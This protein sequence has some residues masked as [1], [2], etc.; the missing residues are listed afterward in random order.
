MNGVVSLAAITGIM[1][2]VILLANQ[3]YGKGKP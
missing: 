3:Y 2:V 1:L